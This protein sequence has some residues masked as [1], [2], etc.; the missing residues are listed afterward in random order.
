MWIREGLTE[1]DVQGPT[2]VTIGAFDGVHRGHQALIGQLLDEAQ[3]LELQAVVL[4]FDPLPVQVFQQSDN[5]LLSSLEERVAYLEALGLDGVVVL[6]FDR[7]LSATPARAFVTQIVEQLHMA[8]LWAGPDFALGRNR[9]GDLPMLRRLGREL[10]YQVHTL[11]PFRWK[12]LSV[13]SSQI[14]E[15]LRE[16]ALHKANTL[17][18][19]PY[20]LCG[21]VAQGEQRGRSL[22]FPTANLNLSPERLLPENG[23]Y[24][25]RAY[26]PQG[27]FDAVT[28]VGTR[29]TFDL[30]EKTVEA[31]LLGFSGDL[32][33]IPM[34]LDFLKRLRPERRFDSSEALVRQMREDCREARAWLKAHAPGLPNVATTATAVAPLYCG[35]Q[36][37]R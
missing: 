29:P 16:G 36:K 32:Y 23:I 34:K 19:R 8:G 21:E 15:L 4:T 28:N 14:R 22:G 2:G 7:E 9:E 18:G 25:C 5:V 33:G 30:Q 10:G 6:P 1:L 31:Y 37:K 3:G 26:V 24:V 11:T 27:V 12:G 35:H 20:R 13:R 17:L